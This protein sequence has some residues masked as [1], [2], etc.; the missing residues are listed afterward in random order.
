MA[1]EETMNIEY[2]KA[3][4]FASHFTDGSVVSIATRPAKGLVQLVF[5]ENVVDAIQ[6]LATKDPSGDYRTSPEGFKSAHK[7]ECRVRLTMTEKTAREL[8]A[9]LAMRL[10][11]DEGSE[12]NTV[13]VDI[14]E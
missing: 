4:N 2:C 12:S 13:S 11:P 9:T 7:K 6:E 1:D 10:P 14:D 3:L 8:Q 5:Y